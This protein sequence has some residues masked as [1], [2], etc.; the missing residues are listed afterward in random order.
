MCASKC[1]YCSQQLICSCSVGAKA[2]CIQQKSGF[3]FSSLIFP[4]FLSPGGVWLHSRSSSHPCDKGNKQPT[5]EMT[6][7]LWGSGVEMY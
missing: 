3:E 5:L 7:K 4:K 6:A 1:I 2:T